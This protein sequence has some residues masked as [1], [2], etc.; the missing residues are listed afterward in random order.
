M[1]VLKRNSPMELKIRRVESLLMAEGISITPGQ[2]GLLIS[3]LTRAGE[4]GEKEHTFV[5][6]QEDKEVSQIFPND[7]DPT[8]IQTV[9]DFRH[10]R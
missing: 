5:I 2:G 8:Y 10:G 1:K 9:D 4:K 3:V 6:L 7:V